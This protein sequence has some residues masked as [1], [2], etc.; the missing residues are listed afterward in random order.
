MWYS[1]RLANPAL[2]WPDLIHLPIYQPLISDNNN[3]NIFI[4]RKSSILKLNRLVDLI[5]WLYDWPFYNKWE[6]S[7]ATGTRLTLAI[8]GMR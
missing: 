2:F 8:Y 6:T 1:I 3:I 5:L 7:L 4:D